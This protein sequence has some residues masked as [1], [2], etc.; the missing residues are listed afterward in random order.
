MERR[1]GASGT[2]GRPPME[3]EARREGAE[4]SS[5]TIGCRGEWGGEPGEPNGNCI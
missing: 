2:T 4:L 3:T 1:E 5:D